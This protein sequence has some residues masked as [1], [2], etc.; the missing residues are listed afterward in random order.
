VLKPAREQANGKIGLRFTRSGFG[1]PFF[2]RDVQLRVLGGDLIVQEGERE[3]TAPIVSLAQAA[4][5]VGADLLPAAGEGS[6]GSTEQPLDAAPLA[7][8][9]DAS[10]FL[11]DWHGFAT[12]VL[13][14]LRASVGDDAEPSRVQLWPEHFDISVE[15]GAE[16]AGR[17][18]GYGA[19]P[20]DEQHPE[21]Y[22]YVVPWGDTPAGELWQASGFSG[23]ELPYAALLEAGSGRAQRELALDFFSQRLAAL[24][25]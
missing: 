8:D 2:G 12:S 15:L 6:A 13:E 5:H 16:A 18:A 4:E 25:G 24:S 9:V 17:R 20:G 19:S 22:L 21:P 14:Q 7:I 11:G 1:T 23:A 3:R 10:A